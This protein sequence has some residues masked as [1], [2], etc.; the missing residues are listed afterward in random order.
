M[1]P[2]SRCGSWRGLVPLCSS[3]CLLACFPML[4]HITGCGSALI[5]MA[6]R[7]CMAFNVVGYASR[8][9]YSHPL[10]LPPSSPPSNPY[11]WVLHLNFPAFRDPFR[12]QSEDGGPLQFPRGFCDSAWASLVPHGPQHFLTGLCISK[13]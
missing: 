10:S 3:P 7:N 5:P 2:R 1:V 4:P 12:G 8:S 11:G 9:S 6:H 13:W